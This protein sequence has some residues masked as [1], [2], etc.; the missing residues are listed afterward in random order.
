[1]SDSKTQ[2]TREQI[3]A[4][5]EKRKSMTDGEIAKEYNCSRS[6]IQSWIKKLR[7]LGIEV[8]EGRKGRPTIL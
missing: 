5:P 2:L 8:P 6:T 1:M 3:L 7:K 4:I